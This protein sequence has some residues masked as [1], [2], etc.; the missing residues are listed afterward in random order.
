M[1]K[2]ILT[3][4][5]ITFSQ[6][7]FAQDIKS[8]STFVS[9]G[10]TTTRTY[11]K[12]KPIEV[13]KVDDKIVQINI[14]NKEISSEEK[15][16]TKTENFAHWSG[17][18][19]GMNILTNETQ[20]INFENADYWEIDPA[21]SFSF[22]FNFAEKK[23][24][25]FKN[26]VGLTTGL[27]VTF[28]NY[29]FRNN[30]ILTSDQDTTSAFIDTTLQYSKN[31]LKST[32]FRVPLLLEICTS[33]FDKGAYFSAGVVGGV[34]LGSKVKREGEDVSNNS[35]QQKIKS[36]Y[37]LNTFTLDALIKF[38]FDDFGI[39][40]QYSLTPMFQNNK[41]QKIY[42]FNFGVTLEF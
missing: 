13:I 26:Y 7:L 28:N 11:G 19:M 35:F 39:F 23:V 18:M 41:T 3:S 27:G 5:L 33:S 42:P 2:I 21:K 37:N 38:G 14:E 29:S 17:F 25:L 16:K 36:D 40:A 31:K 10:D 6:F 1:K 12:N 9:K 30:Y 24:N 34:R 8:D 22:S 32:Y 20:G 15:V 4:A